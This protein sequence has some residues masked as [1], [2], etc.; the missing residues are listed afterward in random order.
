MLWLRILSAFIG[1][2]LL[3]FIVFLGDYWLAFSVAILIILG[4]YEF[5]A[6][7]KGIN[8]LLGPIIAGELILI[9]GAWA[10]S[11]YWSDLGIGVSFLI[12]LF[13]A[14]VQYPRFK[15]KDLAVNFFTLIYVG[16]TLTHIILLRNLPDGFLVV[17]YLF[18]VIWST[19]TGAYFAGRF[20]GRKKLAPLIS[21]NK[22]KAGAIGGLLMSLVAAIIFNW[23]FQ[24]FTPFFLVLSALLIS[25]M[26]Q[27]GDL[28]ESSFKRLAGVKDSGH[29]IPGHGGILDRFDSTTLTA[30]I[31]FY[32]L[33]FLG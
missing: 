26:G 10:K 18:L 17:I 22:T 5:I 24:V 28:V 6:M 16:W 3:I 29:I 7:F 25:Y 14:I 23:F 13:V 27:L 12:I 33:L 8:F 11:P 19:D 32:L 4:T 20:F 9:W 15:V 21:P 30:P 31:L 2:P 1:I